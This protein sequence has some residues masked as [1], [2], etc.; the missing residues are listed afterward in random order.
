[1]PDGNPPDAARCNHLAGSYS[2]NPTDHLPSYETPRFDRKAS[3]DPFTGLILVV[4]RETRPT[5]NN[6][7]MAGANNNPNSE[8]LW[9]PNVVGNREKVMEV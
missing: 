3:P 6:P 5:K 4:L 9:H 7:C 1:M 8:K 2:Y